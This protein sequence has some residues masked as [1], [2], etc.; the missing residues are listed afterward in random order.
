MKNS[1]KL[2]REKDLDSICH[3][4]GQCIDAL[5]K[6]F[7]IFSVPANLKGFV[8]RS[9]IINGTDG[10]WINLWQRFLE[11]DIHSEKKIMINALACTENPS[12]MNK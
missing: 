11:A 10:D 6:L 3:G 7:Y 12:F 4:P 1:R 2:M 9:A 5:M 8:Y